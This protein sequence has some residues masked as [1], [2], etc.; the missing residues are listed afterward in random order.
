MAKGQKTGGRQKGTPN[1]L[2]GT[3]K[4]MIR[5]L[6]QDELQKM[7]SVLNQLPPKERVESIIKLLPYLLPKADGVQAPPQTLQQK[8]SFIT[9]IFNQ[10]IAARAGAN[11]KS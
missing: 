7:P 9:E 6:L 8:H 2:S 4:E 1:R 11:T 3:V 10:S 5:Q